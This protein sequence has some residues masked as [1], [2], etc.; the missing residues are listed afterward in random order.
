MSFL[1][2]HKTPMLHILRPPLVDVVRI[3]ATQVSTM[4]EA[5]FAMTVPFA[6]ESTLIRHDYRNVSTSSVSAFRRK[7]RCLQTFVL[8]ALEK[9]LAS[10]K[11]HRTARPSRESMVPMKQRQS[12]VPFPLA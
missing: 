11:T 7:S 2:L 8:T 3:W 6:D 5:A 12:A 1:G 10:R 9:P 4:R